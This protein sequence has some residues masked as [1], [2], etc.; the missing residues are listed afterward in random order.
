[1]RI[2]G[3]YTRPGP[4][5]DKGD[6]GVVVERKGDGSLELAPTE[7]EPATPPAVVPP[8]PPSS[9]QFTLTADAGAVAWAPVPEGETP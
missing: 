8:Q 9:G 3:R 7:E 6:P 2:G 1:M 5:G 4:K